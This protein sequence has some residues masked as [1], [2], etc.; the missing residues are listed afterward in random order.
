MSSNNPVKTK[1]TKS[2]VTIKSKVPET[3]MTAGLLGTERQGHGARIREDGLIAT[4]GY[5][6]I[7]ADQ[8]WITNHEN[9]GSPGYI[10][11]NDY[12]SGIALIKPTL[13]IGND[14]LD[15]SLL[16]DID[17][18]D[19]LI[20]YQLGELPTKVSVI[21]KQEFTGRWEYLLDEAL[22]TSPAI[23]DWAGTALVNKQGALVGLG[24]LLTD[25]PG[26][27]NKDSMGNMYIP[28]ELIGPYIEEMCQYGKRNKPSRPWMGVLIQEYENNLIVVGVYKNCPADNAGVKPGDIVVSIAEEPIQGLA[29]LFRKVWSLGSAGIEVPVLVS[30]A[31]ELRTCKLQSIDRA[32]FMEQSGHGAFN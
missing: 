3:A 26:E 10:V 32:V 12:D 9:H 16:D 1:V 19:D 27:I 15:I 24:S 7:E 5:L 8:I 28:M 23:D 14:Y 11:A 6:V 21:A 31:G 13:P 2:I 30:T 18:G 25:L 4:V 29:D 20:V 22:F 17:S